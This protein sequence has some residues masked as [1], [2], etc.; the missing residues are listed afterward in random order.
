M[1]S[2]KVIFHCYFYC[3]AGA[4]PNVMDNHERTA[5]VIAFV[6]LELDTI[7][8]DNWLVP[9][10]GEQKDQLSVASAAS[11]SHST[12]KESIYT[13]LVRLLVLSGAQFPVGWNKD[14]SK[15]PRWIQQLYNETKLARQQEM[16]QRPSRLV[17]LCRLAIRAYMACV[18]RLHQMSH[19]PVP[20]NLKGYLEVRYL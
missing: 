13:P 12:E 7:H 2:V 4:D 17:H 11:S 19:V 18:G 14:Y 16:V 9:Q 15:S 20:T 10:S 8:K 1:N 5:L 6:M 3:S